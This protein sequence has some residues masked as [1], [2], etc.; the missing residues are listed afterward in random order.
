MYKDYE[1]IVGEN[2]LLPEE[3]W[4]FKSNGY[5][6]RILE[7]V[8]EKHGNIFTSACPDYNFAFR[9]LA[10]YDSIIYCEKS[11]IVNYGFNRSNGIN[12]GKG[13]YKNDT[14]DFLKNLKKKNGNLL[15]LSPIPELMT[16]NNGII[17]EY[18]FAKNESKNPKFKEVNKDKYL[19]AME[20][21]IQKFT[22]YKARKN[23]AKILKKEGAKPKGEF[24]YFYKKF[25]KIFHLRKIFFSI[26]DNFFSKNK[27]KNSLEAIE[28]LNNLSC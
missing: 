28:Y 16:I 23:A 15:Y 27:F 5:Y 17:H 3:L 24:Y 21:D 13:I 8:N 22:S 6:N 11:L 1:K 20:E 25:R 18:Y 26:K 7:H 9:I 10:N 19:K 12:F 2:L 14:A 4:N